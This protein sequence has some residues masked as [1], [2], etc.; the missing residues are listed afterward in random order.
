MKPEEEKIYVRVPYAGYIPPVNLTGPFKCFLP[1]SSIVA[2]IQSRYEVIILNP[3][4]CPE[5]A[6]QLKEY[7][8]FIKNNEYQRAQELA[9]KMRLANNPI[10]DVIRD[11]KQQEGT[12]TPVGPN[13]T[14][15]AIA[16]ANRIAAQNG[17]IPPNPNDIQRDQQ[18]QTDLNNLGKGPDGETPPPPVPPFPVDPLTGQPIITP[19]P[20]QT[21]GGENNPPD[22]PDV[23]L[24]GTV[25][26]GADA[27]FQPPPNPLEEKQKTDPNDVPAKK[28]NKLF[29]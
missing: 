21:F 22:I 27:G 28:R 23:L 15:Q 24:P 5:F 7:H 16:E 1:K 29:G 8:A 20:E 17:L 10:A 2:L 6:V 26:D 11:S 18:Y 3:S 9:G 19:D 14:E 13:L 12:T 25:S 4:S